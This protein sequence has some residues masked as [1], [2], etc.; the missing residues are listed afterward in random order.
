MKKITTI[1][2][3]ILC[4]YACHSSKNDSNFAIE[5]PSEVDKI[6]ISKRN[7]AYA[8]L[9]KKG[10]RW[11]LQDSSEVSPTAIQLLVKETIGKIK[12]K[13]PAPKT[14]MENVLRRM[15]IAGKKVE[16]YSQNKKIKSY[17]VGG[18]TPDML[19]TYMLME[20]AKT[21]YVTHI[22]GFNGYLNIR[23]SVDLSQWQSKQLFDFQ[24]DQIEKI[25]MVYPSEPHASFTLSQQENQTIWTHQ[26]K[27]QISRQAFASYF[28]S[29]QRK[30]AEGFDILPKTELDSIFGQ[31]PYVIME[32]WAKKNK[33]VKLEIFHRESYDKMHGLYTKNGERLAHDPN[34]FNAR[35]NKGNKICVIQQFAFKDIL[36]KA[37]DF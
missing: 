5:N 37:Q 35:L 13:G 12:V 26:G 11:F 8:L 14:A 9:E 19:G 33:K 1:I 31:K 21:P 15:S 30:F 10:N 3:L 32:V 4:L 29:F 2:L 18:T 7:G 27:K 17:Y 20:G 16:L 6:F 28:Q 25:S 36:K 24:A 23:F 34:R 22:P